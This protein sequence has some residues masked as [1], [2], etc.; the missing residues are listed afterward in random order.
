ME[1]EIYLPWKSAI[2]KQNGGHEKFVKFIRFQDTRETRKKYEL[3]TKQK[4]CT[5][6]TLS[7]KFQ[8]MEKA[9]KMATIVKTPEST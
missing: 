1:M 8:K 4:I 6:P 5:Q 2:L 3:I 7:K 9:T